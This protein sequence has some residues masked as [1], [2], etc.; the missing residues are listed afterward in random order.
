MTRELPARRVVLLGASNLVRGISTVAETATNL[1][2]APL[3]ILAALGHGRSYGMES[4]VLGRTLPGILR[5]GLWEAFDQR[6]PIPTFGLV[7]DI[8][9]DVLYG[10]SPRLIGDW[11]ENCLTL[12]AP[13]CQRII[14]TELPLSNVERLG[15]KR[16]LLLRSIIFPRARISYEQVLAATRELNERVID[17]CRRCGANVVRPGGDWYG[18]DPIHIKLCNWS[19]AWRE[20]LSAWR[21]DP[22]LQLAKGSMRRWFFLRALRPRYR[23]LFGCV[24]EQK[25]PAG[26]LPDGTRVSFF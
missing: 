7:T 17:A 21:D 2:G 5:S 11:V 26:R 16:F 18:I 20:I 22:S 8:G 9:N 4:R 25:Q 14:V 15:H 24:Q 10:A 3:D 12:L 6:P 23:R 19:A 1:L 13:A